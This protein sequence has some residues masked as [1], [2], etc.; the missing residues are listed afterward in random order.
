MR[1]YDPKTARFLTEDTYGGTAYDP[2]SL[3][4]YTY[5]HNEPVLCF[6]RGAFGK[7]CKQQQIGITNKKA[8]FKSLRTWSLL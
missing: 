1:Y 8:T 6:L 2:L 4:L 7:H 5:C 3:N